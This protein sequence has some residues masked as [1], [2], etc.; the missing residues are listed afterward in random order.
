[1]FL[2]S[3]HEQI[4]TMALAM[5]RTAYYMANALELRINSVTG[6]LFHCPAR[7]KMLLLILK[8]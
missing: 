1:M 4:E 5:K 3:K 8:T 2:K 6:D 7:Q